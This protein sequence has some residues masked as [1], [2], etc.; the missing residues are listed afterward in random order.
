MK[1][2]LIDD[3]DHVASAVVNALGPSHE[4][5]RAASRDEAQAQIG[6]DTHFDVVVCDL[7]IP[8][9]AS[10]DEPSEEHGK[11]VF[12]EIVD[13]RSGT[14]VWVCSAFADDDFTEALIRDK[15]SGDPFGTGQSVP[16]VEKFRKKHLDHLVNRLRQAASEIDLLTGVEISTYGEQL[17]LSP[18]QKRLLQLVA[19][20][21]GATLIRVRQLS[22]G[23]SGARTLAVE[24]LDIPGGGNQVLDCILKIDSALRATREAERYRK[25]A[26][27]VLPATVITPL[28]SE[29]HAGAGNSSALIYS[30]AAAA[31]VSLG[32][33][34]KESDDRSAAVVDRLRQLLAP[35]PTGGSPAT[36]TVDELNNILG[37]LLTND[38]IRRGLE[39]EHDVS[40][41]A[42]AEIQVQSCVQH[43]DLHALNILVDQDDRPI[44]IDFARTTKRVAAYDAVTLEFSLLFHPELVAALDGWPTVEQ[45]RQ[46]DDT[47]SYLEGCPVPN[48]VHRARD[49]GHSVSLGDREYNA[50]VFSYAL[51]QFKFDGNHDLAQAVASRAVELILRL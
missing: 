12:A 10:Q 32:R 1:V 49:W 16:L 7:R 17:D 39:V 47:D 18:E 25:G 36:M 6:S 37:A 46:W 50:S 26:A 13:R 9:S 4:V 40:I 31:P 48:F 43:G 14:P 35:W 28:V 38:A 44:L 23:L 3:E 51:R 27:S 22:G 30:L 29:I 24:A 21:H 11:A 45:A 19:R 20:Q 34:L 33:L 2:L 42:S 8:S 5:V 41:V 15:R